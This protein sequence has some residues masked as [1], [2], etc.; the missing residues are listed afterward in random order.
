MSSESKIRIYELASEVGVSSKDLVDKALALGFSVKSHMSSLTLDEASSV[1]KS[2][3][4][5][6]S[7]SSAPSK[8]P[9]GKARSKSST[10]RRR[11]ASSSASEDAKPALVKPVVRRRKTTEDGAEEIATETVL[12]TD[13][14]SEVVVRRTRVLT[15]A[16]DERTPPPPASTETNTKINVSESP[17]AATPTPAPDV[18][19]DSAEPSLS[20]ATA[21]A[22]PRTPAP[23]AHEAT[24]SVSAGASTSNGVSSGLA[25]EPPAVR[26]KQV[27]VAGPENVDLPGHQRRKKVTPPPPVDL[28]P[29][30]EAA[31]AAEEEE[32]TPTTAKERFEAE[33]ERARA[34][35]TTRDEERQALKAA[36]MAEVTAE[37]P[38]REDG[39]PQVGTVIKLPTT[40]IKVVERPLAGGRGGADERR[41]RF[42]QQNQRGRGRDLRKKTK[43]KG[44][45][46]QTQITTP[47]EHKRVVRIEETTTV[48]DLGKNMGI[49]AQDLLK[50]V[51]GLGLVGISLNA[52]IDIDT[53]QLLAAEFNYEVQNVAFKED[54]VF[55]S[56]EDED[57]EMLPRPPVVTVM[58]HVD[59]GKTSLLDYIRKAK[60]ASGEA[61]GITQHIGAYKVDAGG[62]Y[63]E[64]VFIDTPGHAAF[65]EMRARGAQCTDIVVL[66]VA[67]D[68]GVMP[69][70]AEAV[71]H[72]KAAGVT[73]IV[74][75]NK[76]DVPGAN[77]ERVRQQLAE[78]GLIPEEWGG[79]T[80]YVDC[81]AKTG[82]GI[83]KLLESITINAELLELRANPNKPAVGVVIE[84]RL[85]RSR[86]PISTVLIQ[87]GTLH[88]GDIVVV[89][90]WM[91]KV[92]AAV[93]HAGRALETAG[94]GTPVEIL[95]I[96]G[97]PAAGETLH[98]TSDEKR[99]KQVV[100]SRRQQKRK[101]ELAS[102][103]KVSLEKLMSNI[104]SGEK[105]QVL[106]IV[107]K[108]DVQGS[109]EALKQAL[110]DLSTE[111]VAVDV[112]SCG[113]GGITETDVNL[114]HGDA[115]I[116]GFHVRKAGKAGQLAEKE[117]V[118][119]KIYDI[120]YD[121]LDDVQ[122][123]M[124]GMLAPIKRQVE[125]GQMEV[126]E[127]FTIPKRG[128]V[129]GC[130]VTKGRV[131]RK[132]HLR[133]IR[134]SAQIYEGKVSSLRRFKDE[135]SEV[136]DGFECGVML[137]GFNDLQVGDIIESYEIVEEKARL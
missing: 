88:L 41:N 48:A 35:A 30:F 12:A 40:R 112:I 25:T 43:P 122:A 115:I 5:S 71:K 59:H 98:A 63:G 23:S 68:D 65:S 8:A 96:D 24:A 16:P 57:E 104:Q 133:V 120:I 75:V 69:Q 103:G 37:V 108:A 81:S 76:S 106:N 47:A 118:Q 134:D 82:D 60:I 123:A 128:V 3:G 89:G 90:E 77:P 93:D 10:V 38:E 136:K 72:A 116:V 67:A 20:Q 105:A 87:G 125:Q 53:A 117:G 7:V 55:V 132:S 126:R 44:S 95:G 78:H 64:I 79:D 18:S 4:V 101:K 119:I 66:I 33:L 22:D 46:R 99:A 31:A 83:D 92:R 124:E 102:S 36:K 2:L 85:D 84:A 50:K 29:A 107:L 127:T 45:G 39:R 73:I 70:T 17:F 100:E 135:A 21:S 28:V 86:G 42:N 91:G 131:A 97:V 110:I 74:A 62:D 114:A 129:A 52:S 26:R 54:D 80:I 113:V 58:G 56:S 111:K 11:V 6:G 34:L 14:V 19:R 137:D 9:A 15:P 51:W 1:K 109:A 130:M 61:G 27:V 121:A 32:S 13:S 94:P 49:K